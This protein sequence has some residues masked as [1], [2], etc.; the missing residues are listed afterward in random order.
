MATDLT[1]DTTSA[2]ITA[3]AAAVAAVTRLVR[4]TIAS[5]PV[6][7]TAMA[8]AT[9][10][11]AAMAARVVGRA[12]ET[13]VE[14]EMSDMEERELGEAARSE[15]LRVRELLGARDGESLGE[16]AARLVRERDYWRQQ[17]ELAGPELDRL[18][19]MEAER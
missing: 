8:T 6:A 14:G 9:A 15:L 17:M 11:A 7:G 2:L 19:R 13:A 10:T 1:P 18:R 3:V 5:A 12:P 4:V 16:A